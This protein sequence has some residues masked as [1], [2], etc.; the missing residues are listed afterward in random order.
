MKWLCGIV[1][2]ALLAAACGNDDGGD[3]AAEASPTQESSDGGEGS[4]TAD[5]EQQILAEAAFFSAFESGR[6]TAIDFLRDEVDVQ[7]VDQFEYDLIS[8]H[9]VLDI[10]SEWSSDDFIE[11]AAWDLTSQFAALFSPVD[12]IWY[13]PVWNPDFHL[14]VSG[15]AYECPGEFMVE[16]GDAR[17]SR[18]DW[19]AT[20]GT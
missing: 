17:A 18:A 2:L 14:V 5:E 13:Q 10:T 12:G 19:E 11:D 8:K 9:V 4:L 16:L 7:S 20:C 3:A 1:A 15:L 6:Q